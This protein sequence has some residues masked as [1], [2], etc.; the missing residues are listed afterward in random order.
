MISNS[1]KRYLLVSVMM[2]AGIV[3]ALA[4]GP[5]SRPHY[6]VFSAIQRDVYKEAQE[7]RIKQFWT[8]YDASIMNNPWSIGSLSYV[9]DDFDDSNNEI[10][11]AAKAKN[12]AEMVAYL[13]LLT[14]YLKI[15]EEVRGDSW[16]YPTK[17]EL[18]KR[19]KGLRY[20]NAAARSYGGK[21]LVGQYALLVMRTMMVLGDHSGNINYWRN[22]A[23]K[24]PESVY[25]DMMK[26]IYAGALLNTGK[27]EEACG[28]FYEMADW[29]SLRWIT[30]EKVN[31]AGI[32]AEYA[33]NPKSPTLICLVQDFVNNTADTRYYYVKYNFDEPE[34]VKANLNEI[35]DFVAFAKQVVAEGKTPVPA[36][37]QSA[38]GWL[39]C[40]AGNAGEGIAQLEKAMKMDGT[41]RMRD[42]ARVCRLMAYAES[43]KA[44]S[45]YYKFLQDEMGWLAGLSRESH[46]NEMAQNLAYDVLEPRFAQSGDTNLATAVVSWVG[47]IEIPVEGGDTWDYYTRLD[48]LSSQ[49]LV[50]YF[51]L[52]NGKQGSA[53]EKW[54]VAGETMSEERFNDLEGTKLIREGMFAKAIPFLEKVPL[55]Y[56]SEQG[57]SRYMANRTYNKERWFGRQV[58]DRDW[59]DIQD[60]NHSTVASNQKLEFCRDMVSLQAQLETASAPSDIAKLSYKLASNYFQASYKGD[61][62]YLSRYSNSVGDTVCFKGEMDFMAKAV[63]LLDNALAQPGLTVSQTQRYLYAKAFIPFGPEY[64]HYAFDSNGEWTLVYNKDCHFYYSMLALQNYAYAHAGNLEPYV[65]TCDILKRFRP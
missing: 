59:D 52:L 55:Q 20:I 11:K 6:Y 38:L 29:E 42:N 33:A 39:N 35:N 8:D 17:D 18:S 62:W 5:W 32:K 3:S 56:I 65:A 37:W 45:K 22:H 2:L 1:S 53:F 27:K 26:G 60:S 46:Y 24:L 4:C 10:I 63:Q 14:K 64:S 7:T 49:D 21:R 13:R 43:E 54:L 28:M 30:R 58:V 57:I 25:K 34:G 44:G 36:L 51:Q 40:S 12:D 9:G 15:S 23:S 61:C 48:S 31:I 50:S 47:R 41:Q 16:D 19:D